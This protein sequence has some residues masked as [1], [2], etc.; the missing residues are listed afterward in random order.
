[1]DEADTRA[2]LLAAA[3]RLFAK[4]GEEATSL[5]AVTRE[6]DANVAAVHYHFGGRAGL[7]REVLD[8]HIR[9][10]NERRAEL[11]DAACEAAGSPPL[12]ALIDAFVRP[13]LEILARL[14][15]SEPQLARFIGRAYSEPSELVVGAAARQFTQT[16]DRFVPLIAARLPELSESELRARLDLMVAIITSLF[17]RATPVGEA[18]PLGV[19][20]VDAQVARLVPVLASALSAAPAEQKDGL[21]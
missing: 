16:A 2:R 17:A 12:E 5:R 11:L 4:G 1:M 7:L 13:D 10:I 6:A 3:E 18:P 9:P 20:G 21:P 14:R 8:R 15:Q 19:E